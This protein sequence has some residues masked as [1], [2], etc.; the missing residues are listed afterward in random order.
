VSERIVVRDGL[1]F[2]VGLNLGSMVADCDECRNTFEAF[3]VDGHIGWMLAPRLELS[4]DVWFMS[5]VEGFLMVYQNITTVAA[6]WWPTHRLWLKLGLGHAVA[7]Y[8][9][10][11]IFI[12]RE[13]R[14]AQRPAS[15]WAS[16][17]SSTSAPSSPSTRASATAPAP[18]A[19][20]S[21]RTTW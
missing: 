17:T 11:G 3:G 5:H 9:W 16:A 15:W 14:T 7:G 13:D 4:L 6:T 18:T 8:R 1:T 2:G 19:R 20:P 21:A 12:D 10:S